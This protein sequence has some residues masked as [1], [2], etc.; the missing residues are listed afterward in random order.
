M[1]FSSSCIKFCLYVLEPPW[2]G[3][4]SVVLFML[5]LTM[6]APQTG[7]AALTGR[8]GGR[9]PSTP[10]AGARGAGGTPVSFIWFCPHFV[11]SL[12]VCLC[13]YSFML[14]DFLAWT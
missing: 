3:E 14:I 11:G 1:I 4:G 12:N 8:A 10:E 2:A 9:P 7:W 13:F 5:H 6:W